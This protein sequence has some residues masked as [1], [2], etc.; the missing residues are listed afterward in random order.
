MSD[1]PIA[2]SY[3]VQPQRLLAG[4]YPGAL[5]DDEAR[6]KL[7][8][9][10]QAGV[11]FIVDLTEA[12]ELRSY[13]ALLNEEATAVASRPIVH[14]REAIA[15]FSVPTI[16]TM[17]HIL[18]T[19]DRALDDG[20]CVYV[21]CWGGIGRTGTVIGCYLVRHGLSGEQALAQ[22]ALWREGTPKADRPSPETGEQRV[23]VMKWSE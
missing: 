7:Q 8:S 21:H 19:I 9:L 12:H 2:N 14:R 5:R 22:I 13:A 6:F 18:D 10:W 11:T 17:A 15:D 20:H 1:R 4:E 23:F 16:E 3:W